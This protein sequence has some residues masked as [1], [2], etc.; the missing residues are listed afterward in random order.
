MSGFKPVQS[1]KV[2]SSV[3][4]VDAWSYYLAIGSSVVQMVDMSNNGHDEP[5]RIIFVEDGEQIPVR[6][7]APVAYFSFI[8]PNFFL[9]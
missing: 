8:A 6:P 2:S 9:K 7:S 4:A 5:R 1:L 3:Q